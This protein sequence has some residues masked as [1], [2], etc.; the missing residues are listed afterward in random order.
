MASHDSAGCVLENVADPLHRRTMAAD[1]VAHW[2][3]APGLRWDAVSDGW[4]VPDRLVPKVVEADARPCR[5]AWPAALEAGKWQSAQSNCLWFDICQVRAHL[6]HTVAGD[7]RRGLGGSVVALD[8]KG[9][10]DHAD[11]Y[12]QEQ[13]AV[14]FHRR[15]VLHR[16]GCLDKLFLGATRVFTTAYLWDQ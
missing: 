9:H 7:A 13:G 12:A 14:L 4:V 5:T 10:E 15:K 6:V 11:E 8:E 16:Y 3:D 1:A 2:A